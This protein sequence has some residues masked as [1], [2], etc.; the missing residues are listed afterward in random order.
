VAQYDDA[1]EDRGARRLGLANALP[2]ALARDELVIV[3]QPEVDLRD[4]MTLWT[5][6]LL[7]WRHPTEGL[8]A[9]DAFLDIAEETGA[10]VPIGH[11]MLRRACAQLVWWQQHHPDSAPTTVAVNVSSRQLADPELIATIREALA[12][13]GLDPQMLWLEI[14]ETSVMQE[15]TLVATTLAELNQLGVGV[16]LDDFGT[17]YSSLAYLKQFPVDA[18]K[19]DRSFVAGMTQDPHDRMIVS[20]VVSLAH[21]FGL[22]AVA[23]GV[24][25]ASQLAELRH[26][27]CDFAQG[28][29]WSKPLE[30]DAFTTWM[31]MRRHA[32]VNG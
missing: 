8:L 25:T 20:A 6:A 7:R 1:A 22:L 2:D 24:E 21:S 32:G 11:W 27:G 23:E 5:E 30:P 13:T 14:T 29:L 9:P 16:A 15:P 28:Y 17:G 31:G 3:Y 18:L 10:I 26:L 19:I 12:T 4:G